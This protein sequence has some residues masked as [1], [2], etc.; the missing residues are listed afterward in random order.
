MFRYLG[1]IWNATIDAHNDA[2]RAY[3]QRLRR[4]STQ[5]VTSL[6][7]DGIMVL[8]SGAHT[9]CNE[10][11]T[12]Q[13]GAGVILGT[14][15]ESCT[16]STA[17]PARG[18]FA[19]LATNEIVK[20]GGR[21]LFE[22]YWGQYVAFVNDERASRVFV[23]VDPIGALPCYFVE[24]NGIKIFFSDIA[25]CEPLKLGH[26]PIDWDQIT[27]CLLTGAPP[28]N[29][30]TVMHGV[31][32]LRSGECLEISRGGSKRRFYWNPFDIA[33]SHNIE[34]RNQAIAELRRT[35][36]QCVHA[37][38]SG[39]R[40]IVHRL[41]GGIDSNIVL[42]CLRAAPT[43]PHVTCLTYYS[44]GSDTDER[45][46]ARLGASRAECDIVEQLRNSALRLDSIFDLAAAPNPTYYIGYL[47]NSRSEARLAAAYQAT[48]M[49]S[50]GSGDG[51]FYQSRVTF[52]AGDYVYHH[53]ITPR[54]FKIAYHAATLARASVW[55][56][57]R[58]SIV[59]GLLR[60]RWSPIEELTRRKF[61]TPGVS[62]AAGS[63]PLHPWLQQPTNTPNGKFW[64]AYLMMVPMGY[65]DPFGSEGDPEQLHPIQS[66]PLVEL[67][68][69]IPTYVLTH[70]GWDRAVAR[71]AFANDVPTEII[72]RRTKGGMQ[73]HMQ[74]V[75]SLNANLIRE[76]LLDGTLVKRGYLDRSMLEEYLSFRPTT[77]E[78]VGSA[79]AEVL[80]YFCLE[81]WIRRMSEVRQAVA[82]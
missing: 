19:E 71:H 54:L 70:D 18:H 46:L 73:E 56:V 62:D 15:F 59:D 26:V 69:R 32:M 13:N 21:H 48:A 38:A 11:T 27:T 58:Q 50:G 37:W 28:T 30:E 53:G 20:S 8:H 10:A 35:T 31:S 43:A 47:E 24:A 22:R 63:V 57:L 45:A 52:A 2:A 36:M 81:A 9:G 72:W 76:T 77:E 80:E 60:R 5:W 75:L 25:D 67:C 33:A 6:S 3:I 79:M 64:H 12:L 17:V 42:A 16:E 78:R 74:S 41:S 65:Y 82:A 1:L 66:Q 49:F 40:R 39:H 55:S 23:I 68:L 34:D 44:P 14:I 51:V 7:R 29:G 4:A 61:T